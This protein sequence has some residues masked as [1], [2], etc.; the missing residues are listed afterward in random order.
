MGTGLAEL[1]H[2]H[3]DT[4]YRYARLLSR[5][6]EAAKDLTQ[7]TFL[8]A[9]KGFGRF[10]GES[11]QATWLIA[12]LRRRFARSLARASARSGSQSLPVAPEPPSSPAP[13]PDIGAALLQ[14]SEPLRATL[15][16]FYF[17]DMDYASIARTL[18]CPIGTVRSRL[19][20]ARERLRQIL[21][22]APAEE[23]AS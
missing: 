12:I 22:H 20:D 13:T 5:N 11:A 1:V 8:E 4:V 9:I 21:A 2:Q 16:M 19:H 6:D 17:D 7:E 14:L 3:Y 10:R 18:G 15:V 23:S